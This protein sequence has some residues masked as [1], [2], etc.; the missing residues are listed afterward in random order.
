[1][2]SLLYVPENEGHI[3]EKLQLIWGATPGFEKFA[4][5][6]LLRP[7]GHAGSLRQRGPRR[8]NGCWIALWWPW[9]AMAS[10]CC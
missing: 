8:C 6:L 7:I 1:M 2:K 10:I 9:S 3:L 4:R 5:E